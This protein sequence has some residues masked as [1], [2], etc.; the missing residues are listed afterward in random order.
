MRDH[1]FYKLVRPKRYKFCFD[2]FNNFPDE[3]PDAISL[4]YLWEAAHSK[5]LPISDRIAAGHWSSHPFLVLK[6]AEV[7]F[8]AF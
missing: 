1:D 5:A 4:W 7:S 2:F 6:I 8:T 3:M